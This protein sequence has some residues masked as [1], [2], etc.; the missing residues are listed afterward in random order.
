M[1]RAYRVEYYPNHQAAT[2]T[3]RNVLAVAHVCYRNLKAVA[4]GTGMVVDLKSLVV[5][6]IF[7]FDL[8]VEINFFV[9]H[10]AWV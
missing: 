2:R 4:A 8:V 3:A 7:D 9:G 5:E 10:V 6:T 1:S